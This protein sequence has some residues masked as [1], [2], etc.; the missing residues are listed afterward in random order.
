[1]RNYTSPPGAG[2]RIRA[3]VERYDPEEG[4]GV[5]VP[6]DGSPGIHCRRPA[7]AAAGL[8]ILLVGAR[9]DCEVVEGEHGWEVWRI[10]A[11]DFSTASPGTASPVRAPA[12]ACASPAPGADASGRRVRGTVKWF[13]PA[14]GYGFLEPEDG[15]ADVFCHLGVVRMCGRETL[16]Q[17]AVVEC[18]IVQAE[19]GPQASRILSVEAPAPGAVHAR[20]RRDAPDHRADGASTAE[21]METAGTVKFY[22]P[23][24][25]FGF[26]APDG[27]G[28]AARRVRPFQRPRARRHGRPGAGATGLRPRG[29]CTA[30]A[31][32]Q[33]CRAAVSGP[34]SPLRGRAPL[35]DRAA[36]PTPM[37]GPRWPRNRISDTIPHRLDLQGILRGGPGEPG[38]HHRAGRRCVAMDGK[39]PQVS[40]PANP[41][42]STSRPDERRSRAGS[43]HG[44][45]KRL[46]EHRRR[47]GSSVSHPG[48]ASPGSAVQ[49]IAAAAPARA[50][51]ARA[52]YP[53]ACPIALEG[54][55]AHQTDT[56]PRFVAG[57]RTELLRI[58]FDFA[59]DL[60]RLSPPPAIRNDPDGG[61]RG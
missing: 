39:W 1:M 8:D 3:S 41:P 13:M 52:A 27:G 47:C 54:P 23:V 44:A 40:L 53:V 32:G 49:G 36:T 12:G 37:T 35:R 45:G 30:R 31:T 2:R 46:R 15:S 43:R 5:L 19:R 57:L 24:R 10:H 18:E 58:L 60:S 9:V 4:H 33:E 7:L 59:H 48:T 20:A 29:E 50:R 14:K 61:A 42:S 11:V 51:P 17:G 34:A 22:D 25:G 38:G 21:V 16:P 26:V 28:R 56:F 55:A 6:G